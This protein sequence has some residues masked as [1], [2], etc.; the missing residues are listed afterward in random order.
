MGWDAFSSADLR[1]KTTKQAFDLASK[2]VIDKSGSVDGSLE[3]GGLGMSSSAKML[4]TASL[5]TGECIL[6][7]FFHPYQEDKVSVDQVKVL[8]KN[9]NWD[10]EFDLSRE[11]R[12]AYW[13]A[14]EFINICAEQGLEIR[15]SY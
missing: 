2:R 6:G 3:S 13:S 10:F 15:F 4:E 7:F 11:E 1:N 5:K 8:A 14:K 9:L 12:W